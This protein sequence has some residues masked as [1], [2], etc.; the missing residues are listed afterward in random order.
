MTELLDT[1]MTVGAREKDKVKSYLTGN[2]K[3]QTD[4]ELGML[5][6]KTPA[7]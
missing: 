5:V 7:N 1:G 6:E 2:F 4:E 3:S